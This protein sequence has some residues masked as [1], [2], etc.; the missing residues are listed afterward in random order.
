[1]YCNLF[2]IAH[3]SKL[4][5]SDPLSLVVEI[6]NCHFRLSLSDCIQFRILVDFDTLP[7]PIPPNSVS[8][9]SK[10]SPSLYQPLSANSTKD[11]SKRNSRYRH[12]S[13]LYGNR[14]AGIVSALIALSSLLILLVFLFQDRIKN[15]RHHDH[16]RGDDSCGQS[17]SEARQA[18]CVFDAIL[19]GW[20][21]WRCHNTA[22]AAEFLEKKNW[23]FFS[24]RNSTG[25]ISIEEFMAGEWSSVYTS[26]EFYVLHCIYAWRKVREAA[27]LGEVL[28]GYLADSHQ[29]NHCEMIM[30]RRTALDSFD[31]QVF[32]KFVSC[33]RGVNSN[34]GRF[35][36]YRVVGGK[37][38]YR[39]Q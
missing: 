5:D 21:P 32:S 6:S 36:W 39:Q 14:R 2:F 4:T 7:S 12:C 30:L 33:P 19:I 34:A 13:Q 15:S 23:S 27:K 28:D 38:M 35:G 3:S 16:L 18:G 37:K 31:T 26:Y 9:S 17:P 11:H 20:V 10:M 22:L 24:G 1:M 25:S 29:V 8:T